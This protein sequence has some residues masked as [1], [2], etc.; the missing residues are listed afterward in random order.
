MNDKTCFGIWKQ[1]DWDRPVRHTVAKD[2]KARL[3]GLHGNVRI[4]KIRQGCISWWTTSWFC[5]A[6]FY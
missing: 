5:C 2:E 4:C 3:A 6:L 1:P